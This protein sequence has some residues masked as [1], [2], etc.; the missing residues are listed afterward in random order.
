M[1]RPPAC[2]V[3]RWRLCRTDRPYDGQLSTLRD[4]LA[5][6]P[7]RPT[8]RQPSAG[9]TGPGGGCLTDRQCDGLPPALRGRM[10]AA[11]DRLT[12]RRPP[13]G[14]AGP[15]GGWAGPTDR[16]TASHRPR[17]AGWRLR[18]TDRP[19]DDLPPATRGRVAAAPYRPTVRRSP[20]GPMQPG[21][22]YA[23]PTDHATA[24]C[25]RL[26]R[27][28]WRLRR[29]DR[30]CDGLPPVLRGRLAVAP[31]RPTVRR[32]PP[33]AALQMAVV[34]DQT[35]ARRPPTGPIGPC[36]FCAAATDRAV[37]SRRPYAAG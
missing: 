19:C 7:D 17:G 22:D 31:H 29:T 30:P 23:G 35:T 11:P 15:E 26:Y 18:R 24:S 34:P 14:L 2:P 27:A 13:A 9:P 10:V 25:R 4:C 16:V 37:A 20:A 5:A 32:L 1:R 21:G 8:V 36:A 33:F 28:G 3:A 12:V 6:V